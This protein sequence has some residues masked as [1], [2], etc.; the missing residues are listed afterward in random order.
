MGTIG[1]WDIRASDEHCPYCKTDFGGLVWQCRYRRQSV[2]VRG[3]FNVRVPESRLCYKL[4]QLLLL[5]S[6]FMWISPALR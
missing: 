1:M 4:F 6:Y 5:W 2:A 3:V